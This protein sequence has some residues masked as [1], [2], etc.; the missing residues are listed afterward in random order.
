MKCD[1][2]AVM[3]R[4]FKNPAELIRGAGAKGAAF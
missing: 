4:F 2:A 1:V 3:E